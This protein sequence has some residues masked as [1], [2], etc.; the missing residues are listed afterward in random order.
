MIVNFLDDEHA[1][2]DRTLQTYAIVALLSL[3]LITPLAARQ[4]GRLLAPL[5]TLRST[6]RDIT[7]TDLSRRIPERGNDDITALTRTF[8]AMLDRLEAGVRRPAAVPRRRRPRA[9][10]R[11]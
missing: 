7:T 2:L 11:R 1:E 8:N 5:R 9:A 3:G 6:A 4:S 10:R